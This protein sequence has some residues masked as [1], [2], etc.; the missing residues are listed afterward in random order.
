M[1]AKKKMLLCKTASFSMFNRF[2]SYQV[3]REKQTICIYLP[4]LEEKQVKTDGE[5]AYAVKNES[6]YSYAVS[7]LKKSN[8]EKEPN[9]A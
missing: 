7:D 8:R 3:K 2:A 1:Q 6:E 4:H 9:H 5:A